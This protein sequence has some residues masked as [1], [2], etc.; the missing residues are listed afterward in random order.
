MSDKRKMRQRRQSFR[1]L[2]GEKK[3]VSP[4]VATLILILIA[5]A[6][7]AA[8][9]LW[10]VVW[11]GNLTKG[12]GQP[13]AQATLTIGGSTSVYPFSSLGVTWFEQNNSDVVISDN[14][15]GTGAGM[16]AVCAGNIDLGATST[17]QTVGT[18]ESSY[19]CPS[20][21]GSTITITTIAYDA[22]DVIIGGTTNTHG[23]L[24]LSADTLND[25]Y[26]A[27]SASGSTPHYI[28][29]MNG[30]QLAAVSCG[31]GTLNIAVA[32]GTPLT[33]DQIPAVV[34]GV[35][36]CG[37]TQATV[38]A[39]TT[40]TENGAG[41]GAGTGVCSND[42]VDSTPAT[43][44]STCGFVI[45]AG[46]FTATPVAG[47]GPEAPMVPMER[48]DASGTTQTFEAKDLGYGSGPSTSS[49]SW[50]GYGSV[51]SSTPSFDA[52]NANAAFANLGYGGCGS[53][54]LLTDCGFSLATAQQGNGNP[55]VIALVGPNP[56]AI[57][58]ASDGDA[59]AS[60]SGVTIIPLLGLGE[61]T[62][63]GNVYVGVGGAGL[64][65]GTT[66]TL[67]LP[68]SP[69]PSNVVENGAVLPTT[70]TT[71]T[72]A[73]GLTSS[74]SVAQFVGGRPFQLVSLEPLSGIAQ[75]F[76][77]FITDPAVNAALATATHEVGLYSVIP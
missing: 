61:G 69:A 76:V 70:G 60:G 63:S 5:V 2:H 59:R 62:S 42:I 67:I 65:T 19:G 10:L 74:T 35:T 43:D 38:A 23:L 40:A 9:Y 27:G 15:G 46:P 56:N 44:A 6:A 25:I 45:C 21:Y 12:I 57:G 30:V 22:V 68:V 64:P 54:N 72:I 3:A 32:A 47:A 7:A 73:A 13:G 28:C 11:Q 39:G 14:Q 18:L 34:N 49:S 26:E 51:T 24:S 71:G 66:N 36:V 55:G 77:T 53:N 8:L 41:L 29:S 20:T 33:W 50:V 16:V 1:R 4:V 75:E 17:P 48:S 31:S 58:Y 37:V 52:Q